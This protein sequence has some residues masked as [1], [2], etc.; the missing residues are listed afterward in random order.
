MCVV[1]RKHA[2]T[3]FYGATSLHGA[4]HV[5]TYLEKMKETTTHIHW[6]MGEDKKSINVMGEREYLLRTTASV[7]CGTLHGSTTIARPWDWKHLI[8]SIG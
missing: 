5:A 1:E 2:A 3:L 7:P 4:M 6:K 8:W